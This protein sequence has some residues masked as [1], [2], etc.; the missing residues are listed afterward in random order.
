M[1]KP[2]SAHLFLVAA[3]LWTPIVRSAAQPQAP[4]TELDEAARFLAGIHPG[5][6]SPLESLAARPSW[7]EHAKEMDRLWEYFRHF[8]LDPIR[9][10]SAQFLETSFSSSNPVFYPFSGPDAIYPR[11]FFP[12]AS[13]Y[14]LASREEPGLPPSFGRLLSSNLDGELPRIRQSLQ[15]LLQWSFSVTKET[16]R[17][18]ASSVL[19][20]LL[21]LYSVLLVRDGCRLLSVERGGAGGAVSLLFLGP[22]GRE[23]RLSYFPVNLE[24]GS[25]AAS[26]LPR[27]LGNIPRGPT[28]LKAAS[29]LLHGNG[30]SQLRG[31]ILTRSTLV[32]Q[33]DSGI[34]I[35]F[36]SSGWNLRFFGL[37]RGPILI[38]REFYQPDL[39]AMTANAHP[40]PL[41]FAFG[42]RWKAEEASLVVATRSPRLPPTS[43]RN[44]R[45]PNPP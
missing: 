5:P 44:S 7:Q 24:D 26:G 18:T 25:L 2:G 12:R 30:F 14:V 36:F 21:P 6:G 9:Q 3:L 4:P 13:I 8:Q 41:P 1:M 22:E 31:L 37:Y 43:A 11:C 10:W 29:Y 38:F 35:R 16:R 15:W 19:G 33:D 39:A 27:Y 40:P 28:L 42:Y 45:N 32:L 23:Q 34:P 17:L 20:G